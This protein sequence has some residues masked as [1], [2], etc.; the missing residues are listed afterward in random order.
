MF[1]STD[2]PRSDPPSWRFGRNHAVG[3]EKQQT[4]LPKRKT[5][6]TFVVDRAPD[7]AVTITSDRE[8]ESRMQSAEL[9]NRTV[10]IAPQPMRW[11]PLY[12]GCDGD[13]M[14]IL[15]G[16]HG[17]QQRAERESQIVRAQDPAAPLIT[18]SRG[19]AFRY[20]LLTDGRRQIL[21]FALPGDT[22][23]LDTLLIGAPAYPAQAATAV[24]YASI[25]YDRAKRLLQDASWFKDRALQ[26]LAR[27]RAEAERALTRMGQC[28]AEENVASVL[29]DFYTRLASRGLA[30]GNQFMLDL[31][32][33]QF[34]DF[35]GMTVVHL[36]RTLGSLRSRRLL[37]MS[38][39]TVTFLDVPGLE[40]LALLPRNL[41]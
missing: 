33:Q 30:S 31:T 2:L 13:K 22:I 38:G 24:V 16:L 15:Q 39:H 7:G 36:N 32:Q 21:S 12:R 10:A 35:V 29:L 23:G 25:S 5:C 9:V 11:T 19:W 40:R 27:E 37:S 17:P 1:E 41:D 28:K 3:G 34:A 4:P 14:A 26:A 8:S 18:L 20:S 6:P